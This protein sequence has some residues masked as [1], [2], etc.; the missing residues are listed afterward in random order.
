MKPSGNPIVHSHSSGLMSRTIQRDL[1]RSR[2]GRL[3]RK[4]GRRAVATVECV[5][6]LPIMIAITF[7]TIDLC[8]AMFLKE[9]LTIAAYE[10]ARVGI[11]S[12]GT[13]N[14]AT[15]K[16]QQLLTAR[17]VTYEADAISISDPSFDNANTLE[18]V[19]VTVQVPCAGNIP[20]TGALFAGSSISASVTFR[21]EFSNNQ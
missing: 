6:C 10:G 14:A 2:R 12:G 1:G 5:I 20:M 16:V 21:K 8:S 17:G 18:N 19:T 7:A 3:F 15:S 11:Q 4:A 13:N 9:S